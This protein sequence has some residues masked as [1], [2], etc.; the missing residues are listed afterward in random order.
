VSAAAGAA[1]S[2]AVDSRGPRAGRLLLYAIAALAFVRLLSLPWY[3]LM[4]TTEAR[5]ADIAR[6][7]LAQGDWVTPWFDDGVPFW[8]KPPLSFWATELGFT[9]FGVNEWGARLP[10]YLLG[11]AVAALAW[12][13]ARTVSQ[14]AAWHT[15]ALLAGS[16][17]FLLSSGAVMTDMAMTLGNS[18]VMLGFW[19]AWHAHGANRGTTRSAGW[20]LVLGATIG[21]LAKGPVSVVLWGLPLLAWALLTGRLRR[22]WS[23]VPWLRGA[24]L[25]A[26]LSLPWYGLAETRTPGFLQYFIVGEHWQRFVTP[27]WTGDLYGS[28]HKYPRGTI[29]LFAAGAALPWPVLLLAAGLAL[30]GRQTPSTREPPPSDGQ[31]VLLLA[32]ALTPCLFFT[33]AGNIL[34]TYVLPGLPP[35]A[36]LIARW[37]ASRRRQRLAEGVLVLGLAIGSLSTVG[38]LAVAYGGGHFD[39]KSARAL[40]QDYRSHAAAGE[41]LYF[42]GGVPFSGSFYSA[43][44]AQALADIDAMPAAATAWVVMNAAELAAL[45]PV[46][47]ERLA[48][49]SERKS[50][51]E[52]TVFVG[53]G[54]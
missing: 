10:H 48:V 47:R 29:W 2:A 32:W 49:V 17:L 39:S 31:V 15:V 6:R 1:V 53:F 3:P 24:L 46:R 40:V 9:V 42:L 4:D 36:I 54:D 37:T 18:M 26:A 21:L 35:L 25:V 50:V 16:V 23:C 44:Q 51:E 28:A 7:M 27:G 19:Q 45:P 22:A 13:L 33:A 30:T 5:Y 34:W 8:G 52:A 12:S 43:G 38:A 11:V 41:R 20:L 14:R